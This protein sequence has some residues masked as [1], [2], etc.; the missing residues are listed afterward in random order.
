MEQFD[1]LG[2]FSSILTFIYSHLQSRI[3]GYFG[4]G[5]RITIAIIQ[6]LHLKGK[7]CAQIYSITIKL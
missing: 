3:G 2:T 7:Y 1:G 6:I 5:S 4:G